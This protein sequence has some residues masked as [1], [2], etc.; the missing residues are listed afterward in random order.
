MINGK[1]KTLYENLSGRIPAERLIHDDLRL[2]AFGTDAS[3]YRLIPKLV[4][5]VHNEEEARFV[6]RQCYQ[7][8]I[9]VTV[10]ASGTSLSGQAVTNSV[11]MLIVSSEWQNYRIAKD[12]S[13]ITLQ[14]GVLGARA[15]TYL[16]PLRKRI[17]PDPASINHAQIGGIVANNAAGMS[18]GVQYNSY[19][20]IRHM[21]ILFSDGTLLD[22]S[23]KESRK[24]F[25]EEKKEFSDAV[26]ALA[27]EVKKNKPLA[28][29]IKEKFQIKNTTGYSVNALI[30]YSDPIDIIMHLMVG[31]EGTLGFISEVSL[32]TIDDPPERAT[33]LILFPDIATACDSIALLKKCKVATAELMDRASLRAVQDNEEMPAYLKELDD[34]VTALL[35]ETRAFDKKSLQRQVREIE[36]ALKDVPLARELSF[37]TDPDQIVGL[38][39]VRKGLF[40]SV[41]ADREKGTTVLIEDI[42]VPYEYLSKALLE[43]Q[44]LFQEFGYDNAI[45]WGHA[46]D[47]N[48]HFVL[49]QDFSKPGELE[50]YERFMN[51]LVSMVIDQYGGSLKAEHGTGRNMAP[52]VEKEWGPDIYQIMNR[53]KQIFDPE[54]LLN[55]GVLL[56]DDPK[57]HLKNLKPL[58]QAHELIDRCIECGFCENS[59]VSSELTLSPRQR[60][61]VFREIQRLSRSG[62][63]P[64]RLAHLRDRFDYFGDQT[65][66][67][68]GLCALSCPVN[69]DTGLL[70]KELRHEKLTP[71]AQRIAGWMA[72]NMDRVTAAMRFGLGL[73]NILQTLLGN[74]F[75]ATLTN[76]MRKLSG[77]RLPQWTP[78]MPAAARAA[79]P[80]AVNTDNPHKVVYFPTCINRSMGASQDYDEDIPLIKKTEQ[81]LNKAGYEIIYPENVNRLCCGMA[82]ASKGFKEIGNRLAEGLNLALLKAT[83]NGKYPVLVDMSPCL[84]RMKETLSPQLNLYDPIEFT[85][86]FLAD[87]LEFHPTDEPV[88]IF[89]VC[90]SK[91]MGLEEDFLTLAKMCSHNVIVNE[92]NC[93]GFAGDRGFTHPELNAAGLKHLKKQIPSDVKHGYSTSR[94]CEI[95]LTRHSGISYQ[96]IFY[97]VDEVTRPKNGRNASE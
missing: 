21:R 87:R 65:C 51:R 61:V 46:F 57:I 83:E 36:K 35:V 86:R 39:K 70:I 26:S 96:S 74:R 12:G 23:D 37:T 34:G 31:S 89:S 48:V 20:T 90:S 52:F 76:G 19:H 97:L 71:R 15:N 92:A 32:Q 29:R 17:G 62:E 18:S 43:L 14:P 50:R 16:A 25:L 49:T 85:L 33:S 9:P 47:G 88:A 63:E 68:D 69:I 78:Y 53:I 10:R 44:Q 28:K 7:L 5:K 75:M 81:L 2:L 93:C 59:C 6:M 84:H 45:I 64:H 40:T 94:T 66:A 73:L 30:D 79:L 24:R 60:I 27:K 67:T 82:Y 4:V 54:N 56:N 13:E 55:P 8:K 58:P 77:N 11:L 22:T 91:K 95:G 80:H 3:F 72:E 41:A 1:Y 38:W 42:A